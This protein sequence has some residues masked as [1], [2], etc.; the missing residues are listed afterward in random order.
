MRIISFN[1]NLAKNHEQLKELLI[2]NT[3]PD[4]IFCFQEVSGSMYLLFEQY[5]RRD[6]EPGARIFA[7]P[8]HAKV[9]GTLQYQSTIVSQPFE[10][11]KV[12]NFRIK[13]VGKDPNKYIQRILF[14]QNGQ[15]LSILNI[16]QFVTSWTKP[17]ASLDQIF[18]KIDKKR[19]NLIVGDFNLNV[20]KYR[21]YLRKKGM[22]ELS[23]AI[24]KS[25]TL[26]PQ[27]ILET[28]LRKKIVI[29]SGALKLL[30]FKTDAFLIYSKKKFKYSARNIE[31]PY[32]DHDLMILDVEFGID[33]FIY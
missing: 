32:S 8:I 3:T 28:L 20:G 23:H 4:T 12:D 19:I 25:F 1:I 9:K 26:Y 30:K 18:S 13:G 5:L 33:N 2:Q 21:K 11:H 6:L 31:T 7:A 16:H 22:V 27:N 29:P 14:E 17:I 24:P 10:I 15:K